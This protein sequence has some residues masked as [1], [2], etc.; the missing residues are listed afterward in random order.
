MNAMIERNLKCRNY[1]IPPGYHNGRDNKAE[2]HLTTQKSAAWKSD[3]TEL[4]G[5][6]EVQKGR[7]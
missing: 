3:P 1:T 2:D 7:I 6:K 4:A 5:V